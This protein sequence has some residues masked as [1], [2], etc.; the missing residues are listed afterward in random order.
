VRVL[1]TGAAGFVG[2]NL[3]RRFAAEGA[4]VEALV[5]RDPDSETLAYLGDLA[6]LIQ[7]HHGDVTART[8]CID[9]IRRLQPDVVLHAAA[10]TLTPEQEL[11]DPAR[12]FDVN[13][14]GTLNLLE[15]ARR[16]ES[17]RFVFVSSGGVYGPS[18]PTP[19][20]SED[21]P[22]VHSGMYVIGKLASEH[23]C[24]RYHELGH[25][26]ARIGR[27]GTGYGPM[28]RGTPSR[29]GT[30]VIHR[31]VRWA[32][33]G[34]GARPLR[35][36]GAE[37]ARDFIHIDDV[38]EAFWHLAASEPLP[39]RIYNVGAP[40]SRPL[41]DALAVLAREVSGLTW[42][43]VPTD[44]DADVSQGPPNARAS[45]DLT[46]IERDTPWRPRYRLEEG[47]RAYLRWLQSSSWRSPGSP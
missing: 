35:T 1:I 10:V 36:A 9:L 7:W 34:G 25:V 29:S 22:V 8:A 28:E 23:L 44:A 11:A 12:I 31:V 41:A 3:V 5:R 37:I 30:S 43:E 21:A 38:A 20:L 13:V 39:E 15:A 32:F 19:A 2:I 46:R 47:V 42:H 17:I 16:A 6:R 24:V 45:M 4:D 26:D 27:M 18:P 40:E 33:E 14:G